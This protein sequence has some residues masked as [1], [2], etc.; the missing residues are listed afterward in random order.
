MGNSWLLISAS[1]EKLS[2][3]PAWEKI[4]KYKANSPGVETEV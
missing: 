3:L 2:G 1:S 4:V